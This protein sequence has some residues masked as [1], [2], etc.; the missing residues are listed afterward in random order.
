MQIIACS[1]QVPGVL[2]AIN[3]AVLSF[4]DTNVSA[5]YLKTDAEHGYVILD[6]GRET[7]FELKQKLRE[8]DNTGNHWVQLPKLGFRIIS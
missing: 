3:A 1:T 5:Q 2:A 6:V 7:A 8:I 4:E